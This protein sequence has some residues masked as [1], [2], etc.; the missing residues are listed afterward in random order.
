M[1]KPALRV[2]RPP[3]QSAMAAHPTRGE[4]AAA[5]VPATSR[6]EHLYQFSIARRPAPLLG[7]ALSLAGECTRE[8]GLAI[9]L[10][11]G[12][13]R[14]SRALFEQTAWQILAIDADP[15][16]QHYFGQSFNRRLPARVR[17]ESSCITQAKL[18]LGQADLV[19]AGSIL[20]YL[21]PAAM[22]PML[23]RILDA[24]RPGGLFAA[25]FF[26]PLHTKG[27]LG[28]AGVI[29]P[30][31]LAE[32]F[33]GFEMLKFTRSLDTSSFNPSATPEVDLIEVIVRKPSGPAPESAVEGTR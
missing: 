22:G 21:P 12:A 2:S 23:A 30:D 5:S 26:G 7:E 17:F 20:P 1:I 4:A 31:A 8:P 33:S 14:E 15:R 13:G 6:W 10:G 32:Q 16:A 19:W 29:T 11:A 28:A 3:G 25:D 24:L 9:D 18:P 27:G